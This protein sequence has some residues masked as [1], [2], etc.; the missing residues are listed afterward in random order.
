MELNIRAK[1]LELTPALSDYVHK[2]VEKAQ[3]YSDSIIW[4]QAILSV[5]KHR[6]IAEL[7]VHT[8][9]STFR[10]LGESTD[11]YA[12]ID[13]AVH[14][15]DL[16]LSRVKDKQKNHRKENILKKASPREVAEILMM[17]K[18]HS[19]QNQ[20]ESL[21]KILDITTVP[22]KSL[23]LSQ[24]VEECDSQGL[25]VLPF[26]DEKTNSI[27]ILYKKGKLGYHLIQTEES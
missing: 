11:L 25:S 6:Q 27:H 5:E 8:P 2:K 16:H 21:R 12:A 20:K 3:K 18:N 19:V 24:A 9:G 26:I 7:I 15:L 23:P 4:A 17:K 10:T 13:S 14:K 22:L 1:H